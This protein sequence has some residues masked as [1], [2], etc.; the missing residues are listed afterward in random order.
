MINTAVYAHWASPFV[1][2]NTYS[3]FQRRNDLLVS[4]KLSVEQ[5]RKFFDKIVFYGDHTGI[6][7]VCGTVKFDEV[8]DDLE[9]LTKKTF[10]V[11]FGVFHVQLRVGR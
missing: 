9:Q 10:R 11:I 4:M 3:N 2:R 5:S 7:Q 1:E 8:Y 6:A